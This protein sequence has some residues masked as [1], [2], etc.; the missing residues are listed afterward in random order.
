M[1]IDSRPLDHP[2]RRRAVAGLLVALIVFGLIFG[3][4]VSYLLFENQLS[5]TSAQAQANA[6]ASAVQQGQESLNLAVYH[7]T[8]GTHANWLYVEASNGG[9]VPVVITAVFV[10]DTNG[11][12]L[13][14]SKVTPGSNYLIG[15]TD[16]N[17]TLPL[18]LAQGENTTSLSGCGSGVG[19]NIG[20]NA[21]APNPSFSYSSGSVFVNLLTKSGNVFSAQYPKSSQVSTST[22]TVGTST[23]TVL[24]N[25]T[26]STTSTRYTTLTTSSVLGVGFGI[27]TNS[28]LVAMRACPG[29]SP[30]S[31]NCGSAA[32]VYEG[33]EVVLKINV[34]N[35]AKVA[36]NV[37][38][39]FQ[40]IGTNG[41]KVTPS[42]PSS[43]AG[44][45]STQPIPANTG[46]PTTETYTCTFTGTVGPTGGT[47]TFIGDAVGTYTIAPAPPVTITSAEATSNPLPMGNPTSS[48][49]GPWV[50]NYFSFNYASS[51]HHAWAPAQVI[52]ASGNHQVWFQVQV[53]NTAN[54]SL[55][56]L[57]YSYL[58]VVRTAQEQDYY[59]SNPIASW[60]S[61]IPPDSCT[62]SGAG[63]APSG[64]SCNPPQTNCAVLG[65][66]CVP[67]GFSTTLTFAACAPNGASFMW[68]STGGG[69]SACSG[70]DANFAPPE[71]LVIFV[72][73]VFDY[74]TGG[75]WHTFAQ[76]LP[77][78]GV[79]IAA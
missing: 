58:Q 11:K 1:Q 51:E 78:F 69:N 28:L 42:S 41:A 66:S 6:Q 75:T 27:G 25:T 46:S 48:L 74:Y 43:C 26:T 54:A 23:T 34:T 49:V 35:Y 53:T 55:T 13:S 60:Q 71:G 77:A 4:G 2:R 7:V 19:C 63:G 73:I 5:L 52:S 32:T 79:Y 62:N 65:N 22:N 29:T 45:T 67:V 38:V 40:S 72:V 8:S 68:A 24:S 16:L 59:L 14:N 50:L 10:T 44:V 21:T 57:Q 30:F 36:I 39:S 17:V 56:V 61:T 70:N 76:S 20:I 18:S 64:G 37:Y 3:A 47:V 15:K 12:L 33:Q 31:L 9:G